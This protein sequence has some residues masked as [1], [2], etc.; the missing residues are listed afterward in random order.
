MA[1]NN[2][3]NNPSKSDEFSIKL[4][5]SG[6]N[7][8]TDATFNSN[9]LAYRAEGNANLVLSINERRQILRLLKIVK[10]LLKLECKLTQKLG[11]LCPRVDDFNFLKI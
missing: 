8:W 11:S 1:R 5:I 10:G 4:L 7:D 6:I 2:Q 9:S 3:L